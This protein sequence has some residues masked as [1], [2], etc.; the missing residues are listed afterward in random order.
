MKIAYAV[1]ELE[2]ETNDL[3]EMNDILVV[4][5]ADIEN[6]A[7]QWVGKKLEWADKRGFCP[8]NFNIIV[9]DEAGDRHFVESSVEMETSIKCN[10]SEREAH[11]KFS[12][13]VRSSRSKY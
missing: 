9:L 1:W 5:A 3:V 8:T 13:H 2:S 4:Q 6:A 7:S 12:N 10:I 11:H